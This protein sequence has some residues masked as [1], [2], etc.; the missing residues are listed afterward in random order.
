LYANSPDVERTIKAPTTDDMATLADGREIDLETEETVIQQG[1][2]VD[3]VRPP[4]PGGT[5]DP[6][7]FE[8][9]DTSE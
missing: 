7:V 6:V 4:S 8:D 3:G 9:D 2:D 5:G 1:M